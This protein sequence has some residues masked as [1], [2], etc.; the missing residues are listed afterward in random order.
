MSTLNRK[1]GFTLIELLVVIVIL[2][3][4]V[5]LLL[6]NMGSLRDDRDLERAAQRLAALLEL[7]SE[8]AGM[9]GRELG[10]RFGRDNYAF[11]D[12]DPDTGAWI[13]LSGDDMLYPRTLPEDSDFELLLE[14]RQ[15][16]LES[17]AIPA[18][19]DDKDD[20]ELTIDVG[21]A[22]HVA[23]LSSGETTPFTLYLRQD[24]SRTSIVIEGD[25][26]GGIEINSGNEP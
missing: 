3:I 2:G 26:L 8:E 24:F 13:A 6:P 17:E 23:L 22:P 20:D 25:A 9:Q 16:L 14:E 12:L 4:S 15:I 5:A 18:A 7:A 21:P 11:V 1:R 19:D 10:I